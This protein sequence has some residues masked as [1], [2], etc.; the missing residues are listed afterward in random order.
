MAQQAF[1]ADQGAYARPSNLAVR[2]VIRPAIRY[3]LDTQLGADRRADH[4]FRDLLDG[5]R[6]Q[7]LS[8]PVTNLCPELPLP[9]LVEVFGL[10]Y[11]EVSGQLARYFKVEDGGLLVT[12]VDADSP[13]GK[14]GLRAGDVIVKVDGRTADL[15]EALRRTVAEM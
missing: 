9:L 4:R 7:E 1:R 6:G 2:D 11:Q 13:A 3:A 5:F 12:E 14:A 15:S 10:S 8:G